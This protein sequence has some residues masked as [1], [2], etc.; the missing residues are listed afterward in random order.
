MSH[1][2][3]GA[4]GVDVNADHLAC[5]R[6][7]AFG[8]RVEMRKL[9]FPAAAEGWST[10]QIRA[11]V[12]ERAVQ[13]VTWAT[14]H[15]VPLVIEALDFSRK[16]AAMR[17]MGPGY[18]RMLSGLAYRQ[19]QVALAAR[20]AK[21]GIEVI[22]VNPAF[23]S[24]IGQMKYQAL[25]PTL[26]VHQAATWVIARRG[27]NHAE[28]WVRRLL[29]DDP[30]RNQSRASWR[31][32]RTAQRCEPGALDPAVYDRERPAATW[33][34]PFQPRPTLRNEPIRRG[35]LVGASDHPRRLPSGRGPAKGVSAH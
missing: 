13:L 5:V 26:T 2:A 24:K 25:H 20:A 12:E 22:A 7:D 11:W 14:H 28:R 35:D 16:K 34:N 15:R 10:G 33:P 3:F 8:N 23:T 19:F 30:A 6:V 9:D 4:I 29:R 27:M 18:A 21:A 32:W 1:R 31:R 17:A